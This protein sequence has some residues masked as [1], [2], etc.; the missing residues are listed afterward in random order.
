MDE[1]GITAVQT[2]NRVIGRR[3]VKQVERVTS[4]ERGTLP[5]S[6]LLEKKPHIIIATPGRLV[7]HLVNTKGFNL[8]QLKFLVMD[9]PDRILNMD[10]E[11]EVDK[12]LRVISRERRTLLFSATMTKKVQK[13]Q[14]ASLR[15]PA[16]V[17][18]STKYQT[19]EKLQQ[20]Y[21]FIPVKFKACG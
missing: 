2:P 20:Y 5:R 10:F 8:R 1:T 12:I 19:V 21:V 11:V 17:E 6:P 15:N 9:E 18:V 7:D 16:K 3:G 14:R 13:L 4:A